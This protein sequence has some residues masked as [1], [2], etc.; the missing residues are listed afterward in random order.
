MRSVTTA[1]FSSR[2]RDFLSTPGAG[3]HNLVFGFD[4]F[5][6][7]R[8]ANNHQSGSD[9]RL[10]NAPAIQSGTDLI[11]TFVSGTTQFQWNPIFV[12]SQG[13][14]FQTYSLFANDNWTITDRLSANLGLRWDRNDG[15]DSNGLLV[16]DSGAFSPRLG[17]RVGPRRRSEMVCYRERGQIR[18]RAPEQHCRSDLSCR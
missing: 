11:A 4:S 17:L 7:R 12:D 5:N 10:I 15:V 13:T 1:T 2:A 6:D 3:S 14:K 9:Y 8:L 16:A 18:G